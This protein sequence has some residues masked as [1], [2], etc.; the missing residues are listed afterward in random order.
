M[1]SIE[2]KVAGRNTPKQTI[3]CTTVRHESTTGMRLG[4]DAKVLC[5]T[6]MLDVLLKLMRS[7]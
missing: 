3:A 7:H 6:K 1:T 2:K 4:M 5:S